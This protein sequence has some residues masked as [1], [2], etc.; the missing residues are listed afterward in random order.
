[1]SVWGVQQP[2]PNAVGCVYLKN[3]DRL[4]MFVVTGHCHSRYWNPFCKYLVYH[5]I[6]LIIQ[7]V[8]WY[9]DKEVD[10]VGVKYIVLF[11]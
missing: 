7:L 1:M 6:P 8:V 2:E 5:V 10:V 3:Y 11:F 9:S 4:P